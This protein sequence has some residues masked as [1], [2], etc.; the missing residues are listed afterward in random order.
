MTTA[1][2]TQWFTP[3]FTIFGGI[4]IFITSQ[5]VLKLVIEPVQQF[6]SA[7]GLTANTLLRHHDVISN[8]AG[9]EEVSSMLRNHAAELVSKAEVIL[10]YGLTV[11]IFR[12]PSRADVIKAA[13]ALNVIGDG[14]K[15]KRP[16]AYSV[17]VQQ[18][19]DAMSRHS[20]SKALKEIEKL[21]RVRTT[22]R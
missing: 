14:T 1:A 21:L 6:K 15:N 16:T 7:I 22:Y 4:F 11:A 8:G 2:D 20:N 3:V 12:L 10:W 17:E 13:Q 9:N 18:P 19:G 5:A